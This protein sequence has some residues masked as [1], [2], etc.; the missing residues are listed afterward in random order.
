MLLG[1]IVLAVATQRLIAEDKPF[2]AWPLVAYPLFALA[3]VLVV[4][5][6][7]RASDKEKSWL[8]HPWLVYLGKISYGLYVWHLLAIVLTYKFGWCRPQSVW[9]SLYALPLTMAL[10]HLSYEWIERP[11]LRWKER[12]QRAETDSIAPANAET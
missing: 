6:V 8:T 4:A 1:G 11:F 5:G 12:Y 3:A 10:A 2:A 7:L 9:T